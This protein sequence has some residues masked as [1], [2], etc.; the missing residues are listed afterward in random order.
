MIDLPQWLETHISDI[1]CPN[2]GKNLKRETITAVGIKEYQEDKK[3][4]KRVSYLTIEHTCDYC[5]KS[6]GFDITQCGV[7]EYVFDMI[8]KYGF[9]HTKEEEEAEETEEDNIIIDLSNIKTNKET[10][11][12]SGISQS[13]VDCFRLITRDVTTWEAIMKSVGISR[14]DIERYKEI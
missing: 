11:L 8:D 13:E 5:G 9:E 1:E 14:E 7:K 2:C 10:N 6:Y 3:K 12:K 4:K